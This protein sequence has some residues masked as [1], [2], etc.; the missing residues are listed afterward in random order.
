[1][2]QEIVPKEGNLL[3][4]LPLNTTTH[5]HQPIPQLLLIKLSILFLICL[6][7]DLLLV[8]LYP[9]NN[10]PFINLLPPPIINNPLFLIPLLLPLLL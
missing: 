4:H 2:S 10:L 9:T 7:I 3:T 1:M 5:L 8:S 6:P